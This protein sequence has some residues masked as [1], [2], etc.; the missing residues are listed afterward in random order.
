MAKVASVFVCQQCGAPTSRWSGQCPS[1]GAWNSLV[2]TAVSSRRTTAGKRSLRL[3]AKPISLSQV[4]GISEQR[5]ATG[6]GELDRVLGGGIVP[7]SVTLVAG[8]PGIGKS[9]LLTQLALKVSNASSKFKVQNLKLKAPSVLYVCGE[10]SPSQIKLRI[11]RVGSGNAERGLGDRVLF[12]PDVDTDAIVATIEKEKPGMVIIDSVQ[13]LRTSDLTSA[14]GSVSQVTESASR[15]I[16]CAKR[17]SVPMFLVGHVT[18]EGSIAGPK[19]LEHMV[20]TVLELTGDRLHE[21]RLL[22]TGKNRFGATDEVGIFSMDDRGIQEVKNPSDRFLSDRQERVAG[23]CVVCVLEGTRPMLVEIQ[24]LVVPS[25]LSIPRRIAS[26]VD[27]RR[28]QLLVAVLMRRCGLRLGNQDVYV[29]VAGGLTIREPSS[30]FGIALAIASSVK[31][32]PL[33]KGNVAIGEVGLLGELRRVGNL[34]RRVREAKAQGFHSILSCEKYSSLP[35][36]IR[37][38]FR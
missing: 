3:A 17:L 8:E 12:L 37:S 28:V 34:Q 36:A 22:R 6:I 19:I 29:N 24:A 26:G 15:L 30:D 31:D 18:K 10:E 11:E 38:V 27:Q 20:D 33:P 16:D 1:C 5:I 32:R 7:G 14:A 4:Q 13:T 25:S 2:E 21:F 9:T 23:S 35:V